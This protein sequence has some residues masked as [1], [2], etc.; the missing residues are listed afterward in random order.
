M[1]FI[2]NGTPRS[3]QL[4][5]KLDTHVPK[6]PE[7][8]YVI[9]GCGFA[10]TVNHSTLVQSELYDKRLN[11]RKIMHIGFSDPWS[12]YR[13]HGMGQFPHL[14]VPPGYHSSTHRGAPSGSASA[15]R[16]FLYPAQSS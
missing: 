5:G 13:D 6:T 4:K 1:S 8:Y 14:L 15:V 3:S 11:N 12:S 10:A 7:V 9:I 2:H 16:Q